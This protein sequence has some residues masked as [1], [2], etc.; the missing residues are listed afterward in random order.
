MSDNWIGDL[1]L[2]N[3]ME[4]ANRKKDEQDDG[5]PAAFVVFLVVGVL[6]AAVAAYPITLILQFRRKDWIPLALTLL[7]LPAAYFSIWERL[8]FGSSTFENFLAFNSTVGV[9]ALL[10][11]LVYFICARMNR[12][13]ASSAPLKLDAKAWLVVL[14]FTITVFFML[15]VVMSAFPVV[16]GATY[17]WLSNFMNMHFE[18]MPLA[19]YVYQ[20]LAWPYAFAGAALT[21]TFLQAMFRRRHANGHGYVPMP[22]FLLSLPVALLAVFCVGVAFKNL[23][24]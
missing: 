10:S 19:A 1:L 21:A 16:T 2:L 17:W 23:L 4:N 11:Y 7:L 24:S 12:R 18:S 13:I 9:V 5:T 8:H 14:S 15:W 20:K 3:E 22:L 6:L